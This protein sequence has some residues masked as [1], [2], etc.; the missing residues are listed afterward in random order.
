[1]L[2]G[3]FWSA[4]LL[5]AAV[6]QA[7]ASGPRWVTGPPYYT[8]SQGLPVVWQQNQLRY[9]T[10][11]GD[12]SSSVNHAAADALVANAMAVWNVPQA[13]ITLSQGGLLAEHVS[14]QNVY[15]DSNGMEWPADVMV[16][17]AGAIA[18]AIVYDTDGSVTDTLLGA[19]ASAASSC[20]TNSV[21]EN[22][23]SFTPAGYIT[24][25]EIVLNGLCTGP[26][27]AQQ[28]EMQYKLERAFGRVL[29]LAWSQVND[30]VFTGV[31]TP[32]YNQA[33]HWPIMHPID[34]I[35]GAYSY[36]CLPSPFMLRPDD[37]AG[38]VRLYGMGPNATVPAGK[39][40]SLTAANAV[41]GR[42]AFPDG[43]GMSGV[44]VLVR[45]GVFA[46]SD[47]DG[48]FET[49]SVA[50]DGARRSDTSPF[51]SA[52]GYSDGK[53][54]DEPRRLCGRVHDELCATAGGAGIQRPDGDNGGGESAVYRERERGA[55]WARHG[56]ALRDDSGADGVHCAG[57]DY[58]RLSVC[59]GGK[60]TAMWDRGGWVCGGAGGY[61]GDGMVGGIAMRVPACFVF[62][63][64]CAGRPQL[65]GGGDGA[66]CKWAGDDDQSH[67]GA[68]S[69]WAE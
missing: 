34:I 41:N 16:A 17:N 40:V 12:L 38:M 28:L 24:H 55:L 61:G 66:G 20:R 18:I 3:K 45:R 2:R 33:L 4:L 39:Q 21:T 26:A 52:Q 29:G 58:R 15:L 68:G 30:N 51:V 62:R 56:C 11:P 6:A 67:A 22:V 57:G 46:S 36:Q 13:R 23:D 27:A 5:V 42:V 37:V 35:C 50:G 54:G 53:H 31:P 19:G 59:A 60:R 47:T 9:F 25:A 49:G 64:E 63:G 69:V 32:T 1:M 65:Y 14:G 7:R 44:N 43:G 48:W 10:D 8:L